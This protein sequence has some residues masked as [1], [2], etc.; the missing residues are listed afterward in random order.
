MQDGPSKFKSTR[1][2]HGYIGVNMYTYDYWNTHMLKY[3]KSSCYTKGVHT[4]PSCIQAQPSLVQREDGLDGTPNMEDAL[5][6][7]V[8]S[9]CGSACC[10]GQHSAFSST[11][12]LAQL[13]AFYWITLCPVHIGPYSM[14][15][16]DDSFV[17]CSW[18]TSTSYESSLT[19]WFTMGL[20]KPC[21]SVWPLWAGVWHVLSSKWTFGQFGS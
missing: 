18:P 19:R 7:D 2:Q 15:V 5:A 3:C 21:L 10:A 1:S 6:R 13:W 16:R 8:R 12:Y 17:P 14:Q 9:T 20:G 11:I 4:V